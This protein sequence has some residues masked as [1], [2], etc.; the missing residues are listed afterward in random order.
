MLMLNFLRLRHVYRSSDF[1]FGTNPVALTGH[2]AGFF[3]AAVIAAGVANE[4]ELKRKSKLALALSVK[5]A[6]ALV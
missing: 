5:D 1:S 2:S 3:V 6:V 4:S